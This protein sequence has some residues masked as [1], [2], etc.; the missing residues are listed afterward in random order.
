MVLEEG[1]RGYK[2]YQIYGAQGVEG[3]KAP[4]GS[5]GYRSLG[6]QVSKIMLRRVTQDRIA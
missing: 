6:P 3:L 2:G 4:K 5:K 1:Y